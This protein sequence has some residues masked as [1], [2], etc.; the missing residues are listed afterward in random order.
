MITKQTLFNEMQRA[1]DGSV[2]VK[3]PKVQIKLDHMGRGTIII[4][5]IDYSNKVRSAKVDTRAQKMT[6][7]TL[8]MYVGELDAEFAAP[9][10]VL[11]GFGS[12]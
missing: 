8:E 10:I 9:V 2:S 1:K 5:G 3:W 11:N 12:E 4:D 6:L 7:L